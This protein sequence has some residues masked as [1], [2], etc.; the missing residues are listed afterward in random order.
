MNRMNNNTT[1]RFTPRRQS[2]LRNTELRLSH[3]SH[4]VNK[5]EP[6]LV[7]KNV[8]IVSVPS[9][10][11]SG[12][13]IERFFRLK[14]NAV[15]AG[16][17]ITRADLASAILA[18]LGIATTTDPLDITVKEV[19]VFANR[20]LDVKFSYRTGNQEDRN[21]IAS[22]YVNQAGVCS[23]HAVYPVASRLSIVSGAVDADEFL[24]YRTIAIGT[25][26]SQPPG[27]V[28]VDVLA[29]ISSRGATFAP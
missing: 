27:F 24:S 28:V 21:M 14:V 22:D 7:R 23:I 12:L 3:V 1:R 20:S 25:I 26:T 13:N 17:T 19:K 11:E 9:H 8:Q 6:F 18:E 5:V 29:R 15:E 16:S 10:K 4:Q 2:N